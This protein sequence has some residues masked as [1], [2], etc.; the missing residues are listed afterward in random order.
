MT[1]E[2]PSEIEIEVPKGGAEKRV[3]PILVGTFILVLLVIFIIEW[4]I[5]SQNGL[6]ETFSPKT[7]LFD[8]N[9]DLFNFSELEE[10]PLVINFFASWCA[11]C[12]REMRAIEEISGLWD[13]RVTFIGINSQETDIEQAKN[14]V[15]E[16]GASYT[17]LF[18][19]DGDLLEEVGA[20]GLPFTL[21]VNPDRSIVG[22]YLTDLDK[23]ELANYL[24]KFFN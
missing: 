11:P 10:T 17:I 5:D 24:E 4:A 23:D 22:R 20:V 7:E 13:N 19:G 9:G 15:K 2:L 8:M 14:L 16:T 3:I 6:S 1:I 21:F 12:Q 18:G